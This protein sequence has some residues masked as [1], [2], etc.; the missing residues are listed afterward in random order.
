MGKDAGLL[1]MGVL[2]LV[3]M[4]ALAGAGK[5]LLAAGNHML[6]GSDV[7]QDVKARSTSYSCGIKVIGMEPGNLDYPTNIKAD[8]AM[9]AAL[10]TFPG[11]AVERIHLENENGCHML[12]VVRLSNGM[13]VKVDAG[14][15]AV[16]HKTPAS[17]EDD[18]EEDEENE[19]IKHI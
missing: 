1:W 16:V 14:N 2:A 12:Y 9:A 6:A 8:Q 10:A 4:V 13:E 15:G 11:A 17:S 7:D 3:L 5:G 18:D 19:M